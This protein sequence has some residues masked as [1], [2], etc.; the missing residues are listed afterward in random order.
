MQRPYTTIEK[1]ISIRSREILGCRNHDVSMPLHLLA[2]ERRVVA[3]GYEEYFPPRNFIQLFWGIS[4]AGVFLLN[5]D[6]HVR[7]EPGDVFLRTPEMSQHLRSITPQ[8]EFHWVAFYGDCANVWVQSYHLPRGSFHVGPF[9]EQIFN[10]LE[11]LFICDTPSTWEKTPIILS[12]LFACIVGAFPK[13]LT[14][15]SP[16]EQLTWR[17]IA[18]CRKN[19]HSPEINVNFCAN[20]LGVDRATLRHAVVKCLKNTPAGILNKLRLESA[21]Q[22]LRT[23]QLPIKEVAFRSGFSG[24][25]YFCRVIRKTTGMTPEAYRLSAQTKLDSFL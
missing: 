24:S 20:K 16:N 11:S 22:Y 23:T 3:A 9:P 4:G 19:F 2:V 12:E 13:T 8:W 10:E 18:L 6:E 1:I 17:F 7:L 25:T 15:E 21:L 5:D 14:R